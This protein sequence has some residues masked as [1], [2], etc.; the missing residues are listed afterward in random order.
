MF[1]GFSALDKKIE[2]NEPPWGSSLDALLAVGLSE[3]IGVDS[4][5]VVAVDKWLWPSSWPS[6]LLEFFFCSSFTTSGV[7]VVDEE[8]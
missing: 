6:S 4:G 2:E 8:E 5:V 7:E 3:S 1:S